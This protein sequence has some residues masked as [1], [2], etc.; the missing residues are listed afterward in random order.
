MMLAL[1]QTLA[2]ANNSGWEILTEE[3]RDILFFFT[4]PLALLLALLL[5][6]APLEALLLGLSTTQHL[7]TALKKMLFY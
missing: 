1:H 4:T 6:L 2:M 5:L 7:T 3:A